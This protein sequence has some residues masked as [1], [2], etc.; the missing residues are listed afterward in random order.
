LA[1]IAISL[2]A[3]WN[4]QEEEQTKAYF[5]SPASNDLYVLEIHKEERTVP[6]VKYE[7]LKVTSIENSQI[8]FAQSNYGYVSWSDATRAIREGS[9]NSQDYFSVVPVSKT[10]AELEKLFNGKKIV[11]IVREQ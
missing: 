3:Y 2:G 5:A 1:V 7:I 11:R 6:R 10:K 9:V 8:Q 4:H